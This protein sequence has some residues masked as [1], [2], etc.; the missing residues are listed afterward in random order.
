[1]P[2]ACPP[3]SRIP[4][5]MSQAPTPFTPAWK[6]PRA[7]GPKSHV[8]LFSSQNKLFVLLLVAYFL[9]LYGILGRIRGT[10][11]LK[12]TVAYSS[13]S[14]FSE[15]CFTSPGT[16]DQSLI[17]HSNC[18]TVNLTTSNK[19]KEHNHPNLLCTYFTKGIN[20]N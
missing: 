6:L 10:V 1:M 3:H 11:S 12:D 9:E 4:G 16:A 2:I 7:A 15:T 18:Y 20:L 19:I 17:T 5:W 8:P 14:T 13:R